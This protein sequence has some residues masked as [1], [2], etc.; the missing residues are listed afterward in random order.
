[1]KREVDTKF[2]TFNQ[3]NSGGYFVTDDKAGICE[4]VIIEAM[5]NDDA[6]NKLEKIGENVSGFDSSCSCC[7]ERW[8]RPWTDDAD[9]EPMVYGEPIEK[10]TAG[11][12]RKRAFVH[13]F[14][15]SIKEFV[16]VKE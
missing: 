14:D 8:S 4:T 9:P 7:G 15:G 3:N 6:F 10:V 12:F 1:M 16:F 5:D 2:F 13:Y 11:M